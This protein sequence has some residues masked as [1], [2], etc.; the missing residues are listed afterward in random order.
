MKCLKDIFSFTKAKCLRRQSQRPIS[1]P[2]PQ[3]AVQSSSFRKLPAHLLRYMEQFLDTES[4]AALILSCRLFYFA[5]GT[6]SL[7]DL[8]EHPQSRY[9][10][11]MLLERDLH[12]FILCHHCKKLH[13]IRKFHG[14]QV[15]WTHQAPCMR[16]MRDSTQYLPLRFS[17]VVFQM[18]MKLYRQNRDPS[19]LLRILSGETLDYKTQ[20]TTETKIVA[21][22]L[23][24][25]WQQIL[26][27]PDSQALAVPDPIS[28]KV[29]PHISYISVI[30]EGFRG[31]TFLPIEHWNEPEY[32]KRLLQCRYCSTEF[33][34]TFKSFGDR[35]KAMIVTNWK[36]LGEGQTPMDPVFQRHTQFAYYSLSE[37][38]MPFEPGSIC[39]AFEGFD[40]TLFN[41]DEQVTL[42]KVKGLLEESSPAWDRP[43]SVRFGILEFLFD[44][45][46][47]HW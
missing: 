20:H 16:A 42:E 35:G 3:R 15:S 43:S 18:A 41:A 29:C 14:Y 4:T 33:Q 31:W 46:D 34:I 39:K 25:R 2:D 36:D 9:L 8:V 21:G 5:L 40:H 17:S 24:L 1:R 47:T 30:K 22:S 11:L 27:L 26:I 7:E 28:I 38:R 12:D 13:S 6:K 37:D 45:G 23:L 19:E 10:F 44:D 32:W